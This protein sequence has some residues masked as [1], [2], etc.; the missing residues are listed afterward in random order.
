MHAN[1][2]S[3]G[4]LPRAGLPAL[5]EGVR[6]LSPQRLHLHVRSLV[7]RT[8]IDDLRNCDGF[9]NARQR[10]GPADCVNPVERARKTAWKGNRIGPSDGHLTV[11]ITIQAI[12]RVGN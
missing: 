8:K 3:Q 4:L 9:V 5:P 7:P 12:Q 10:G 11:Y 6:I 2:L 1:P